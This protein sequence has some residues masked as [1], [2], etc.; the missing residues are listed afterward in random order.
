ME[1]LRK[2]T[3]QSITSGKH[4]SES[5]SRG[6]VCSLPGSSDRRSGAGS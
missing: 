6:H 5:V 3:E 1:S 2:P 4:P